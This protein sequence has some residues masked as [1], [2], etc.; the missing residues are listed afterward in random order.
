[1]KIF[2]KIRTLCEFWKTNFLLLAENWNVANSE[3]IFEEFWTN[4]VEVFWI[5]LWNL[6]KISK[7]CW[8]IT[9]VNFKLILGKLWGNNRVILYY[10]HYENYKYRKCFFEILVKLWRK[11]EETRGLLR[12][13]FFIFWGK[14]CD[15]FLS[16]FGKTHEKLLENYEKYLTVSVSFKNAVITLCI[17]P[18]LNI[19]PLQISW[20]FSSY[21]DAKTQQ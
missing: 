8:K 11:F 3:K 21:R 12:T 20:C 1:M 4:F 7:N 9:G 18:V 15:I 2:G 14:F 17:M 16:I 19:S 13:N 6:V 10:R 5:C